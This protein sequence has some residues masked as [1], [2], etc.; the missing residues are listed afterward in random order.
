MS[1]NKKCNMFQ[2][3][4]APIQL[5]NVFDE[6]GV[7][8]IN[9]LSDYIRF[10]ELYNE[11]KN[12]DPSEI[13]PYESVELLKVFERL[14]RA[15]YIFRGEGGYFP[16][17]VSG[18]FRLNCNELKKGTTCDACEKH[19]YCKPYRD[20]TISLYPDFMVALDEYYR[21]VS[22]ELSDA[23]KDDFIA[24]AQHHGLPTNLLDVTLHPLAAL[25]MACHK[26][27][28]SLKGKGTE[29]IEPAYVYIFEDY[30]DVTDI[31]NR[32]PDDTVVE[33]LIQQNKYAINKMID[34][35]DGYSRKFLLS[36]KLTTYT[37]QLCWNLYERF[38]SDSPDVI[39]PEECKEISRRAKI[40][41]EACDSDELGVMSNALN[42]L[43]DSIKKIV[44]YCALP[45]EPYIVLL[46]FYLESMNKPSA[47]EYMPCMI[48]RPKELFRRARLQQG[49]FIVQPFKKIQDD[50]AYNKHRR[51]RLI[52]D[53]EHSKVVKINNPEF[54]L[55]Q[56]DYIGINHGTM[57]GDYDSIAKHISK[58]YEIVKE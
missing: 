15:D 41:W 57:Y 53:I 31:M 50:G 16:K 46:I 23:E 19:G 36:N 29:A 5:N 32:H 9:N 20:S 11:N 26:D 8:E 1:D 14:N 43:R 25:F 21:E 6:N 39:I 56:L 27:K 58:K 40:A 51:I 12:I 34:L 48:Y 7:V 52:Q 55:R 44:K 4:T 10:L 3:E 37:K 33:L 49:F 45:S 47:G 42:E 22:H 17:R 13:S 30:I 28:Y 38:H 35:L 2:E 24:F 54:I 18:A